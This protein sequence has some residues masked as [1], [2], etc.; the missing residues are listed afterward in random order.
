[1]AAPTASQLMHGLSRR[2]HPIV[3]IVVPCGWVRRLHPLPGDS[4]G[5]NPGRRSVHGAVDDPRTAPHPNRG[6]ARL[7]ASTGGPMHGSMSAT[8][9]GTAMGRQR[10]SRREAAGHARPR[11]AP[12]PS[13]V[14]AR[15]A[16]PRL[17]DALV[18]LAARLQ[19]R[20]PAASP[21]TVQRSIDDAVRAFSSARVRVFLP[22]LIERMASEALRE[23][24]RSREGAALTSP[25][26]RGSN[27]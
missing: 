14:D 13:A 10:A 15:R 9:G 18:L 27:L 20:H 4:S 12:S 8:D 3:E 11:Q 19:E 25:S 23:A 6:E 1:M 16:E 7:V 26:S 22:I 24:P 2:H 17:L 5:A 21:A